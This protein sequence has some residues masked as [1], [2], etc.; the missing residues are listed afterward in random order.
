MQFIQIKFA[1][2]ILLHTILEESQNS[3]V[4]QKIY[5]KGLGQ[6]FLD[7][8]HLQIFSKKKKK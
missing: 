8:F 4:G 5:K 6:F 7:I 3:A 2:T 1:F